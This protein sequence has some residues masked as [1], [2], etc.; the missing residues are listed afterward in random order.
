[1]LSLEPKIKQALNK[2]KMNGPEPIINIETSSPGTL[3]CPLN[4]YSFCF[5]S[6]SLLAETTSQEE[7]VLI[8]QV[9][10]VKTIIIFVI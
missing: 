2:H 9:D 1:M 3:L 10:S 4:S 8:S 5:P 6:S 7:L